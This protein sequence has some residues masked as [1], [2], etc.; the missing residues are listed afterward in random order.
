MKC[1]IHLFMQHVY[2]SSFRF[3]SPIII[4]HMSEAKKK[5]LISNSAPVKKFVR[6]ITDIGCGIMTRYR[7]YAGVYTASCYLEKFTCFLWHDLS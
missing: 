1:G 4:T 6:R 2:Q 5:V 7:L 3:L